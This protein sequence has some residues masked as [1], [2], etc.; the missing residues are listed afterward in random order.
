MPNHELE[1]DS[2]DM[3]DGAWQ[4]QEGP[5]AKFNQ[6]YRAQTPRKSNYHQGREK[7]CRR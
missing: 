1:H 7:Q 3:G 5:M 6:D 4:T 2:Q